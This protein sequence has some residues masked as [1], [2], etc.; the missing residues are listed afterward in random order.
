MK[1]DLHNGIDLSKH[2]SSFLLLPVVQTDSY[3]PVL[4]FK[5]NIHV[6]QSLLNTSK[7]RIPVLNAHNAILSN[8]KGEDQRVECF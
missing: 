8:P 5:Y 1:K 7:F 2:N 3:L 4:S 6:H